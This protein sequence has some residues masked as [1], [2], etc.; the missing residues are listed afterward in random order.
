LK[1][2]QNLNNELHLKIKSIYGHGRAPSVSSSQGPTHCTPLQQADVRFQP[3]IHLLFQSASQY[4][5]VRTFIATFVQTAAPMQVKKFLTIQITPK[6]LMPAITNKGMSV[7]KNDFHTFVYPLLCHN[8]KW[9][10]QSHF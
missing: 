9:T 8:S 2:T 1:L 10:Q 3:I 5:A 4:I 6:T 7:G